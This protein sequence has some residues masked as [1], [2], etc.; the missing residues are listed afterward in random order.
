MKIKKSTLRSWFVKILVIL[1]V[2]AM[3]LTGFLVM[4]K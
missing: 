2:L 1:V 4:F 3:I